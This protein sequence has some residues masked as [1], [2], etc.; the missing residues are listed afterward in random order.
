M[1]LSLTGLLNVIVV[2]SVAAKTEQLYLHAAPMRC[3]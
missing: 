1:M 3:N 2:A